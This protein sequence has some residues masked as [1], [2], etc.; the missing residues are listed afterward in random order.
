MLRLSDIVALQVSDVR[1]PPAHPL[2]GQQGV[3][4]A[5]AIGQPGKVVLI[6]T[7]IG[8]GDAELD[9]YYQVRRHPLGKALLK[10]GLHQRDV[11]CLINTHLH[12]DHC[13]QNRRF[14]G[15]PTY[16][17]R[18]EYEAAHDPDYTIPR[19]VDFPGA[20]Y[21]LID[22]DAEVEPDITILSTPGHTPGHQ[23]VSVLTDAG[24]VVI[25]G[26]AIFSAAEYEGVA[27]P[28]DASEISRE[29]ARRLK[30]L[31]PR[32]IYF[33]HDSRYV[34]VIPDGT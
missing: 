12:F 15:V 16:V 3:V 22:G 20:S 27:P 14:A 6:D 26:H 17:Q 11:S 9:A 30:Q 34:D 21:R 32:R 2:A 19:W 10:A 28:E 8:D 24:V 4:Y 1:Y 25:A 29:S 23:S 7:G 18:S 33:S 13:G 5:F 31:R